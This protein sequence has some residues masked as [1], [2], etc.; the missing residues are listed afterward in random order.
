MSVTGG[1]RKTVT[2]LFCDLVGSTS[3][4]ERTDPELLRELMGGYHAELRS[5]IEHHGDTVEKFIGDGCRAR[6]DGR[7][8]LPGGRGASDRARARGSGARRPTPTTGSRSRARLGDPVDGERLALEARIM[9]RRG[10]LDEAEQ[11][12]RSALE[13]AEPS[14][15]GTDPRFT[16]A[17][18]LARAGRADE[19]R[20][21]AEQCLL[22]YRAK[23]IVPVV[24]AAQE[25]LSTIPA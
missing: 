17:A 8:H 15:S 4:G 19:A 20:R 21:V 16:L 18:I 1:V 24:D 2:L 10:R 25:L 3:L 14:V 6:G 7:S 12:A 13:Q 9:A 22:D 11:L 5:I 23:G